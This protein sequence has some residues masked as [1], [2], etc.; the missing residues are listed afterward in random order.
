MKRTNIVLDEKLV[1]QAKTA[2]GLKTVK[3]VVSH[4]LKE[5]VRLHRQRDILKLKGKIHWEG[6][7]DAMRAGRVFEL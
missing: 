6:D 5:L 2:T 4:A 3:A 7:L 1:K